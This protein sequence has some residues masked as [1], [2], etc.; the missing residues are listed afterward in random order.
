MVILMSTIGIICEYNPFHNGHLYH[1]NKIK[2]MFPDSTIV[3]VMSGHFM[4]RG[5][6]SVLN[7][8]DKTEIALNNGVDLVLELPYPFASQSSDIFAHG[9]LEILNALKVDY[10][11]FGSECDDIDKLTLMAKEQ[12]YNKDYNDN[13]KKYLDAGCNY[14]TSLAKALSININTPNDLL[15][16]SYIKE[17]IKNNYNIKPISIKRTNNYHDVNSNNKIISSTNIRKKLSNCEDIKKYIPSNSHN[18][19][20]Y[21]NYENEYFKLLKYKILSSLNNLD[22]YQTV[23]EGIDKRIRNKILA[24]NSLEEFIFNIKTKRYTYNK[25]NRMCSHILLNFTKKE[26]NN[27]KNIEYIRVLGFNQKGRTYLNKIKKDIE[28][29]IFTKFIKNDMLNLEL[30]AT[31]IYALITNDNTIISK[32]YKNKIIINRVEIK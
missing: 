8:W 28:L 11:V 5:N 21:T 31:Y 14:P 17:I 22:I 13:V 26:A 10:L 29:P 9:A 25:I 12:L 30:R 18:Y 23:D 1:I 7:K 32:E 16:L 15:G 19:R 2:E 4:Q 6:I 24:C 27:F 20:Y 3:L